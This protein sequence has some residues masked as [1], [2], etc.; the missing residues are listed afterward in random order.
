MIR[1]AV[2]GAC[3]KMGREVVKSRRCGAH[4]MELV[5]ACDVRAS[6]SR[7]CAGRLEV[8]IVATSRRC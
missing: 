2:L 8:P 4:D 3:G 5:G 1:V 6:R 7:T